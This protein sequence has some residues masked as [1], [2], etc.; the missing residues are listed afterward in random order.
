[1]PPLRGQQPHWVE[2]DASDAY[3]VETFLVPG[4][5]QT[6][7]YTRAVV[8]AQIEDA[9][10]DQV[11]QLTKVRMERRSVPRLGPRLLRGSRAGSS[12]PAETTE[13]PRTARGRAGRLSKRRC[14]TRRRRSA[15][16][17]R[18]RPRRR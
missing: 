11:E 14:R 4:L 13:A 7:D 18:G 9:S 2:A 5:L 15:A 17:H 3:S 10:V 16:G 1:M 8:R 12:R 6:E